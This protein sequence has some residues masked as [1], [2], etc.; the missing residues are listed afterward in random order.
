MYQEGQK[1]APVNLVGCDEAGRGPLAGPLTAGAVILE[2]NTWIP[3][4]NDSKKLKEEERE[5]LSAWIK[6]VAKSWAVVIVPLEKLQNIRT[7]SLEG[8][9]AAIH[10]LTIPIDHVAI[11]GNALISDL[12]YPQSY[13]IKGDS[14]IPAIAAASILAKVERDKL[15]EELDTLYPKYGFIHNKGYGSAQHLEALRKYGP[16]PCHRPNFAPVKSLIS[17]Q[18]ELF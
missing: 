8:M 11:D 4:L 17:S 6:K 18:G 1:L 10:K 13:V 3:G 16:S 12:E 14:H 15:M 5:I 9:R 7:A 2:A